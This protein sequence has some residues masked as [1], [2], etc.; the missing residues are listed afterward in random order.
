MKKKSKNILLLEDEDDAAF[1]MT[2]MLELLG[3][4]VETIP[5]VSEAILISKNRKFDF[6]LVDIILGDK[7]GFDAIREM[8][9]DDIPGKVIIVSANVNSMN[10]DSLRNLGV[11]KFLPKPVKID[12]LGKLIG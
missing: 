12:E 10:I 11:T 3:Y 2:E 7:S 8:K 4:E 9:I 1:M 5:G 6:Y